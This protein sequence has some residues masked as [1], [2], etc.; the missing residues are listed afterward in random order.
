MNNSCQLL[1]TF[2]AEWCGETCLLSYGAVLCINKGIAQLR[3]NF[4]KFLLREGMV[5]VLFPHDIILLEET[6]A[7]AHLQM[8]TYPPETLREACLQIETAIYEALHA[9]GCTSLPNVYHITHTMLSLLQAY[10]HQA[11]K[12][13][14]RQAALHL[15]GYF[16]GFYQQLTSGQ[17]S[18]QGWSGAGIKR[19]GRL[20]NQFMTLLETHHRQHHDA[21]FYA[22][23]LS[24]TPKHLSS[25]C[26]N[27]TGSSAKALIAAYLVTHIKLALHHT[28]HSIKELAYQFCFPS[29]SH[30]CQFFK[31]HTGHTPLRY[32]GEGWKS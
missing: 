30:F 29:S 26:R 8:L 12:S 7:A 3:V 14:D 18:F 11:P 15:R 32:R 4:R 16:L 25:V 6:S 24:V 17:R 23:R 21:T 13:L 31:Q 27:I 1:E 9:D 28:P 2:P 5:A 22:Q 19:S 20:F 10:T